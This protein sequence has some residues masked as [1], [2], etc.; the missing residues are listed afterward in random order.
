MPGARAAF[1]PETSDFSWGA[2]RYMLSHMKRTTLILDPT[3]YA[4]LKRR[5]AAEG[6][7]LTEVVERVLRLGLGSVPA[8][9]RGRV[10]LPSYDMGPFLVSPADRGSVDRAIGETGS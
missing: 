9:R 3:L 4:D 8:G 5:A 7:T 1:N 6:R 10:R 2:F